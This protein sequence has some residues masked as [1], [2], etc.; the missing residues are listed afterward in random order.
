MTN[1]QLEVGSQ[2][3]TAEELKR[4]CARILCEHGMNAVLGDRDSGFEWQGSDA[5][6]INAGNSEGWPVIV[7][8]SIAS[9]YSSRDEE[10]VV[11]VGAYSEELGDL[12]D[13]TVVINLKTLS[14]N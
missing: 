9:D 3:F 1:S 4:T 5:N 12:S 14:E 6:A 11:E 13:V 10:V 2:R 7:S 8:I